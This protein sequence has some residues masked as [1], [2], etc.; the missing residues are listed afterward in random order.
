MAWKENDGMNWTHSISTQEVWPS[1]NKRW[2][3]E[4]LVCELS[5]N[6]IVGNSTGFKVRLFDQEYEGFKKEL[7]GLKLSIQEQEFG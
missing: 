3:P 4:T 1:F 7:E 6:P 2:S 5:G